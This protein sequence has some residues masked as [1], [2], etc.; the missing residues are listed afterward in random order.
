[1]SSIKIP[2]CAHTQTHA[3]HRANFGAVA[4][5]AYI[6]LF[7]Q[8]ID[9]HVVTFFFFFCIYSDILQFIYLFSFSSALLINML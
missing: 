7:L 5:L 8:Q 1:M 2:Q 3:N 4:R 9:I 6:I